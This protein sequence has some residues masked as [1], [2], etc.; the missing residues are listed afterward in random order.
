[1][2]SLKIAWRIVLLLLGFF[3]ASFLAIS[4]SLPVTPTL[5]AWMAQ[6][7]AVRKQTDE[8]TL[9]RLLQRKD[10]ARLKPGAGLYSSAIWR[11]M[12]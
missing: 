12:R 11:T 4:I 1:M 6:Y 8:V 9:G 7:V 3:L 10:G 5:L 2:R